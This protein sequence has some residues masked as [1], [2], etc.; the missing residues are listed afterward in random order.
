MRFNVKTLCAAILLLIPPI[1][2]GAPAGAQVCFGPGLSTDDAPEFG[3]DYGLKKRCATTKDYD[4]SDPNAY[5]DDLECETSPPL[6]SE[7][8]W[9]LGSQSG[10]CG[11]PWVTDPLGLVGPDGQMMPINSPGSPLGLE[12]IRER[13][14]FGQESW[15]VRMT[16]DLYNNSFPCFGGPGNTFLWFTFQDHQYSAA[17]GPYPPAG[18][19]EQVMDV[20]YREWA[21][22][23]RAYSRLGASIFIV[24]PASDPANLIRRQVDLNLYLHPEWPDIFPED[25]LLITSYGDVE[26]DF[27][28]LSVDAASLSP[29]IDVALNRPVTVRIPWHAILEI[30][31]DGGYFGDEL[32][33]PYYATD[34]VNPWRDTE[35]RVVNVWTEAKLESDFVPGTPFGGVIPDLTIRNFRIESRHADAGPMVT[36]AVAC[37]PTG[38]T[39]SVMGSGLYNNPALRQLQLFDG[40]YEPVGGPLSPTT[41]S[42]SGSNLQ[43]AI[44]AGS[45][46]E[47]P[48][49]FRILAPSPSEDDS[50][51]KRTPAS[52]AGD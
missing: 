28:G 6:T 4:P 49:Y 10:Q 24:W 5:V 41:S 52:I 2:I 50:N 42:S 16:T 36:T 47:E 39:I 11:G 23:S 45:L 37:G 32:L 1:A 31:I 25:D 14:T 21:A 30:L 29:A 15:A 34:P 27:F 38:S 18:S 43:F 8:R 3:L 20:H 12:W 33:P 17:G 22:T 40:I 13:N 9:V 7:P 19:L 35:V 26:T 48:Q 44:P 46:A 51:W